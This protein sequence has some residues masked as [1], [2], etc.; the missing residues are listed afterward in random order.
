MPVSKNGKVYFTDEQWKQARYDT[1]A[2]EYARSRGYPLVGQGKYLSMEGHDS[3]IFTK[4]GRWFWNSKGISGGALEFAL[5]YEQLPLPEAV[6]ALTEGMQ[7]SQR[8]AATTRA[9]ITEAPTAAPATDA[10][11]RLPER[12]ENFKRLFGYLCKDRC[13]PGEIVKELIRQNLLYES[14][15]RLPNG[16][17]IHNACFVSRDER[18]NAVGAF[19]RSLRDSGNVFKLEVTGSDKS[20]GWLMQGKAGTVHVFEA[21]IDAASY[22]AFCYQSGREHGDLLALGGLDGRPLEHY[23]ASH[24]ETKHIRFCLD[25]DK[26]GRDATMRFWQQWGQKGYEIKDES[27]LNLKHK[28]WNEE[29]KC[30]SVQSVSPRPA[31]QMTTMEAEP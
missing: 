24:P 17:E 8:F 16:T 23:L 14:V 4:D 20:H 28:D 11:F 21:A 9:P 10:A 22:A 6:N 29:L 3:M 19:Q 25:M 7:Q 2:L 5:Y 31:Q 30:C 1:S 18:G 27:Q 15:K 26:A 13:L 12:A